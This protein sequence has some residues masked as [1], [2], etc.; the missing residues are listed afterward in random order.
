MYTLC[1]M[2]QIDNSLALLG[3]LNVRPSHGYGLKQGYDRFFG[4]EKPLAY[5]QVYST[6]GRLEKNGMIELAG[7]EPGSGPDLKRYEITDAGR[8]KV[9]EWM[10]TPDVPS[11][12][13]RENLYAKLIIA[14]LL[15]ENG[16]ELLE[17]QRKQ[18]LARMRELTQRKRGADLPTT[19]VCDHALFHIEA[20]LR[21]ME[22]TA[23][24]LDALKEGLDPHE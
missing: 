2:T 18:H 9:K 11:L 10:S 15:D 23:S 8:D 7:E 4:L 6:M 12:T 20:D 22:L 24:R 16:A 5:G 21:W 19:L 14:L 1:L 3:L 13:L 17:L